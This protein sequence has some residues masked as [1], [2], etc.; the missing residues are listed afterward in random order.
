MLKGTRDAVLHKMQPISIH[1]QLPYDLHY[2]F[3]DEPDGQMRIAR[4]GPEAI[5]QGVQTGQT[6]RLNFLV[7]VVTGV[8]SVSKGQ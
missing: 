3:V 4:V 8:T 1:C 7:G 2:K 5:A 6:V